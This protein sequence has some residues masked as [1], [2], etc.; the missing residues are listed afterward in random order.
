M[1]DLEYPIL[2]VLRLYVCVTYAW[3][4]HLLEV[5]AVLRTTSIFLGKRCCRK[6]YQLTSL[7]LDF[8]KGADPTA[9]F[10]GQWGTWS[11]QSTSALLLSHSLFGIHALG[12]P[13]GSDC[14]L[15]KST[16]LRCSENV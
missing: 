6:I 14:G 4:T 3:L 15:W 9:V 16:D 7:G 11:L 10:Q 12:S 13:A 5:F 8:L 1:D 2:L